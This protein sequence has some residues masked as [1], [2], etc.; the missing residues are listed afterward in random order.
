MMTMMIMIIS[1]NTPMYEF[2]GDHGGDHNYDAVALIIPK[3]LQMCRKVILNWPRE[4]CL[5]TDALSQVTDIWNA[6]RGQS[7][8]K[9]RFVIKILTLVQEKYPD[10]VGPSMKAFQ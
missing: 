3:C 6:E 5:D 10:T 9:W 1:M 2:V 7:S 8:Q 4:C